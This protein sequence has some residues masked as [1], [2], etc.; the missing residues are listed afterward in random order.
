MPMPLTVA[1][2]LPLCTALKCWS[3]DTFNVKN[4][5]VV[6]R[7]VDCV[8]PKDQSCFSS[9]YKVGDRY[10]KQYDNKQSPNLSPHLSHLIINNNSPGHG[11]L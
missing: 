4:Q 7:E 10:C 3:A 6:I 1:L 2:A 5:D 9:L 11:L 8:A